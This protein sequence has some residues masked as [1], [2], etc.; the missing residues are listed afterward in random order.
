MAAQ[1]R[2]RRPGPRRRLPQL[3]GPSRPPGRSPAGPGRTPC[4]AATPRRHRRGPRAPARSAPARRCA[5]VSS[6][7]PSV[8]GSPGL[9]C[10]STPAPAW[11]GSSLRARPAPSRQAARPTAIAS[12]RV[13]TPVRGAVTTCVSLAAG[14]AASGSPPWAAIIRRHASIADPSASLSAGSTSSRPRAGEH[15]PGQREGQLDDVGGASAGE[16]VDRL[17]HLERVARRTPERGGHVGQQR[18]R[19]DT[20]VRARARPSSRP[21]RGRGRGPS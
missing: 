14:R 9:A 19:G 6:G 8:T 18:D 3:S 20:G 12:S 4:R 1:L 7:C 11:T 16:H 5:G 17:A 10:S 21:A 13:S 2:P 15:L